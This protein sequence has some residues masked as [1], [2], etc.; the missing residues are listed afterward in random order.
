ML[1]YSTCIT[2]IYDVYRV[3]QKC[4]TGQNAISRQPTEI[5]SSKFQDLQR[6]SIQQSLTVSTKYFHCFEKELQLLQRAFL[7][8]R[9]FA[10]KH[11]T[12]TSHF[13]TFICSV[14]PTLFT[15]TSKVSA[16]TV[17]ITSFCSCPHPSLQ[18]FLMA[19]AACRAALYTFGAEQRPVDLRV[20]P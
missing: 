6:I 14:L 7:H 13:L 8:V 1:L 2:Q 15:Y 16:Y 11:V 20:Y 19:M 12:I 9:S 17:Y 18:P 3:A 4:P 5:F 10:F